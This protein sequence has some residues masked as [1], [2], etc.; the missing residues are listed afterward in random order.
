MDVRFPEDGLKEWSAFHIVAL[1]SDTSFNNGSADTATL[2]KNYEAILQLPQSMEANNSQY[3]QYKYLLR[4]NVKQG[5][6]TKF[7]DMAAA[8]FRCEEH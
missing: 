8:A 3:A 1:S 4:Q 6:I 7:Y 2:A 5:S